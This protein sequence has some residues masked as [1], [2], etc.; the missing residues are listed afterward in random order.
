MS[1]GFVATSSF[2]EGVAKGAVVR[3]ACMK[4]IDGG[5]Q[6]ILLMVPGSV[7]FEGSSS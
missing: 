5:S 1:P 6:V 4:P 7:F 2:L 3:V